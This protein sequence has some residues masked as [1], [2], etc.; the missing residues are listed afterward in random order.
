[1]LRTEEDMSKERVKVKIYEHENQDQ[2]MALKIY[3]NKQE[4]DHSKQNTVRLINTVIQKTSKYRTFT[5]VFLEKILAKN[6]RKP[7]CSVFILEAP[8]AIPIGV[9]ITNLE[10][11]VEDNKLGKMLYH[12]VKRQSALTVDI[13]EFDGYPLQYIYFRLMSLEVVER[14]LAN[15][16]SRLNRLIKLRAGEVRELIMPFIHDNPK[17]GYE[18]TSNLL[19]RVVWEPIQ[20]VGMLQK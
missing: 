19:E 9:T 11:A 20:A 6:F 4:H 5:T 3:E 15:P 7:T 2:E 14:K 12:L 17:Y 18:N 8:K 1:M 10:R 13:K 16:Q